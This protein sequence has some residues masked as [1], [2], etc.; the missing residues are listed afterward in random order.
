MKDVI[1]VSSCQIMSNIE[2]QQTERIDH[3]ARDPL[4]LF[5]I[6]VSFQMHVSFYVQRSNIHTLI[7]SVL[8]SNRPFFSGAS[9]V[10]HHRRRPTAEEADS[11]EVRRF[12]SVA[13]EMKR[14][15]SSAW[16]VGHKK[17]GPACVVF[18]EWTVLFFCPFL[19]MKAG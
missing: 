17:L 15:S 3:T 10:R 18:S 1:G 5:D 11:A 2:K 4:Y 6:H 8:A 7:V 9:K 13:M 19:K 16:S 14:M 12:F